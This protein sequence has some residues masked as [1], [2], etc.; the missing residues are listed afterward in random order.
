MLD[1]KWLDAL[2]LPARIMGGL[3]V[4]SALALGCNKWWMPLPFVEDWK[5]LFVLGL[6]LTG[7]LFGASM[8]ASAAEAFRKRQARHM[9]TNR[10]EAIRAEREKAE[11]DGKAEILRRLDHLGRNELRYLA[12]ALR[13]NSQSFT[14]WVHS[15]DLSNLLHK[16]LLT[17][18]GGTHH[19]DHYPFWIPDLI[20]QA[21]LARRY[22]F[23]AKDDEASAKE[24]A[25]KRKGRL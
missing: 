21:L 15:A 4:F 1:V 14:G 8:I 11:A 13:D 24:E 19:Q 17:T 22:D 16:E 20:W 2:S 3:F 6:L 5:A 9:A 12:Q 23:I 25:A 10:R 7:C 18:P